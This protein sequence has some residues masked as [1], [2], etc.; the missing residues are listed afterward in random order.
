MRASQL[1]RLFVR[2]RMRGDVEALAAVF[3]EVAPGLLQ[4]A[5]HLSAR[6][7]EPEDLVQT[8]FLVAIER[9]DSFDEARPLVP[10]MMGILANQARL[11]RRKRVPLFDERL[12][13]VGSE[14]SDAVDLE[15]RELAAAV[16]SA[17]RDLSL[18]H[19]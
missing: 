2:Y 10:W 4:V 16:V 3:D 12:Y 19:I 1:S 18:I 14:S 17:L 7:C 13:E 11:A 8:T 6:T 5:K 15:S 9:S